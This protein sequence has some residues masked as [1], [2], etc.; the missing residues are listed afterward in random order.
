MDEG[1]RRR[2]DGIFHAASMQAPDQRSAFLA[3]ACGDDSELMREV[4]QLLAHDDRPTVSLG[5]H[6]TDLLAGTRLGPYQITGTLG[7]G[8]MGSVYRAEDTRLARTV[9]IKVI[10]AG[11]ALSPAMRQRF[12]REGRAV[13]ALNHPHICAVYD[14]GAQ[15]ESAYLVME[16]VEGE[17]LAARLRKGSLAL[18]AALTLATQVADALAAAHARGIVHRDLKP[19]NIMLS[20]G[21]VKVLDFGLATTPGSGDTD[22]TADITL[23]AAGTIVGTAAYMSP[24]QACGK[25]LDARTDIWSFGCILFETLTAKRVFDGSTVTET[26]AAILEREPAWSALPAETPTAL[27][28]LLKRCLRK[29]AAKRLRDIGDVRLELEDLMMAPQEVRAASTSPG[30]GMSIARATL[31]AA[32]GA[33]AA[34]A[35]FLGAGALRRSPPATAPQVVKFTITPDKIARGSAADI[36]T[37]ISVSRDGRHIAYV[38]SAD[39]QFWLRDID[40]NKAR[41]VPG[42]KGVY[43]AFWSPDSRFI[44]YAEGGELV[45][46]PVE[47]GT[48]VPICKLVGQF[49]RAAWSSDGE[50][51]AYCDN[52]GLHTVPAR[53]GSPTK[54]VAHNHIEHPSF[55]DLPDGRRAILYQSMDSPSSYHAVYAQVI[56]EDRPRF[57]TKSTSINPY[58]AYSPSGNIIYVDGNGDSVGIWALPFSLATLQPTGK[59]FPIAPG[60]SSPQVS[61][62]DTL[63]YS[64]A[65][66]QRQQ[67]VW[68]DR[69]GKTL[70]TIGEPLRQESPSLSPDGRRLAVVNREETPDIWMYDVDRGIK[71]RFTFDSTGV[72]PG[73]WTPSGGELTYASFHSGNFDLF[74]KPAGGNGEAKLLAGTPLA[75]LAPDWSPDQRFLIYEAVSP[76]TK[77]D[78]LYREWRK[79]GTMGDPAVFLKT[80]FNEAAPRFSPD[81]HFVVYSSDESGAREIYV[82][83]FPNGSNKWQISLKGGSA[84]RWRRDGKE[85]FYID[86]QRRLMA[87]SVTMRPAFSPGLPQPLF[88]KRALQFGYDV[89]AD[90]KRFLIADSPAGGPP[91]SIHVVQ[92]W[93]EE[94]RGKQGK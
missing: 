53:G 89:T 58:P 78:L 2:I 92:N 84:P 79:D 27:R 22:A 91:I 44:G 50:T 12:E 63:I 55:L 77:S 24:E 35:I 73:A 20:A 19:A 32:L 68:C 83:E 48:P 37:E 76:E 34:S 26:L 69:E 8:G 25:P 93:F 13:A 38:E 28:V 67:L 80:P 64:D 40:Q 60:G 23:T 75:E 61:R 62:T 81:G 72:V 6:T 36:D 46:I 7:S 87:V 4:E 65:P 54:V 42:A 31:F 3:H 41:P 71:T 29:D 52:E 39:G 94:F 10:R 18:N 70:S 11:V 45:K 90:G 56:G 57:L 85:I 66:T 16:Y 49:R 88:G 14:V 30:G 59:A 86:A 33:A 15:G 74:S 43:Q 21:G 9:A 17:T 82:R 1:Q 5:T 51:I 47:G